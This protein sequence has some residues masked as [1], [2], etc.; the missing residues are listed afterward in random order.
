MKI[1]FVEDE[2]SKQKQIIAHLNNMFKNYQ[3][4]VEK[5]LMSGINRIHKEN[6]D[7]VL[8]DM[9]LPLYDLCEDVYE[10][11]EFEAFAGIDLL[12]ELNR[13]QFL[14]KVIVITAFDV[15][16][17]SEKKL[18]LQQLDEQMKRD[19]FNIYIGSIHYNSSSLEW[20][21]ELDKFWA[22]V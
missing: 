2:I 22:R 17:D 7:L 20:K 11:N 8:L 14:G 16:E 21:K 12:E 4:S 18:N 9:S 3:V 13:I 6:F 19:Y 15:I 5:S 10:I 1:L